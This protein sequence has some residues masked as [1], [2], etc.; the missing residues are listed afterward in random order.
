METQTN[1]TE[2]CTS[3]KCRLRRTLLIIL[4]RFVIRVIFK[5]V[6]LFLI[7]FSI[8]CLPSRDAKREYHIL[9]SNKIKS[10]FHARVNTFNSE[11]TLN[12]SLA[13]LH[14][15]TGAS[16]NTD[17]T[18][19]KTSHISWSPLLMRERCDSTFGPFYLNMSRLNCMVWSTRLRKLNNPIDW[20]GNE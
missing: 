16:E 14:S 13:V 17:L 4:D 20:K 8:E 9:M 18:L 5:F 10:E 15:C 2:V 12:C 1:K 7:H 3:F 11:A 6:F 19:S